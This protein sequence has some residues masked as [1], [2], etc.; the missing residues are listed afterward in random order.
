ME[1]DLMIIY[2]PSIISSLLSSYGFVVRNNKYQ[3]L[4]YAIKRT[5]VFKVINDLILSKN[6]E[7]KNIYKFKLKKNHFP[8]S[9]FLYNQRIS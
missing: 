6:E 2:Y 7:Q 8:I 1:D 4:H 5:K 3:S 9:K